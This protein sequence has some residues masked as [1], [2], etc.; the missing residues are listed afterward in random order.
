MIRS[1]IVLRSCA[2]FLLSLAAPVALLAQ[3]EAGSGALRPYAHVFLAYGVAWLLILFWV[4]RI[5]RGLK[6]LG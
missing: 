6:R 2:A 5:A 1:R 4:W 3:T